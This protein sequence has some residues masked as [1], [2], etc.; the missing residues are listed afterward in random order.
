M[1]TAGPRRI[2]GQQQVDFFLQ[3]RNGRLNYF[4]VKALKARVQLY[5]ANKPAALAEAKAVIEGAGKWFPWTNLK[6]VTGNGGFPDRT[7]LPNISLI[8]IVRDCMLPTPVVSR[9]VRPTVLFWRRI[10]QG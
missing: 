8:F 7:F 2:P 5:R 4:A 10:L 9:P 1:I 6:L 3:Q